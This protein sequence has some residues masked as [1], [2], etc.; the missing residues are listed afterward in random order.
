MDIKI[1][2][3][4]SSLLMNMSMKM[5]IILNFQPDYTINP[6]KIISLELNI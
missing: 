6:E 4:D 3:M 2:I 5:K 1:L